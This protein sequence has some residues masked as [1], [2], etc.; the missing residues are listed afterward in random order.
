MERTHKLMKIYTLSLGDMGANCYVLAADDKTAAAIDIGGDPERLLDLLQK[1]GLTLNKILLTH[2]HFDH[3]GGV[4]AVQAQTGAEVLIHEAD[5]IM[6][7]DAMKNLSG[8]FGGPTVSPVANSTALQDGD[9]VTVGT[10]RLTV[11]HTPGHT[12]GSICFRGD[13]NLF[14]G[15]T[16]F[17]GSIG[18][19]D[20]PNGSMTQMRRSLA[21]L[22]GLSGNDAVYPGH[23]EPTT[24]D[25][26]RQCNPYMR[27]CL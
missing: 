23:N 24:L 9:V 15:D 2:G 16:L 3:I 27:D 5:Q 20:F 17:A 6:L 4:A 19:T 7:T 18:R 25:R 13:G 21:L 22:G 1:E 12:P 11:I 26:E 8:L 10:I 14:S